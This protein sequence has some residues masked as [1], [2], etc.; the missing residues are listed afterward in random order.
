MKMKIFIIFIVA[1]YT[2]S[3]FGGAPDPMKSPFVLDEN[4]TP[5]HRRASQEFLGACSKKYIPYMLHKPYKWAR[6]NQLEHNL[7]E[8]VS[9]GKWSSD[10]AY[11]GEVKEQLTIKFH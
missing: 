9:R 10:K 7:F 2:T 11:L 4:G 5:W 6:C 8:Y 1:I 3:V